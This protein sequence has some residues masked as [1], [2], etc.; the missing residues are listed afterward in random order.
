[1]PVQLRLNKMLSS[2]L[3]LPHP[4]QSLGQ[5]PLLLLHMVPLPLALVKLRH[6]TTNPNSGQC[7]IHICLVTSPLH[8]VPRL[9]GKL[10][11]GGCG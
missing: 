1:M 9:C 10:V 8:G 7:R 4:L 6:H 11:I 5:C 3:V 2:L